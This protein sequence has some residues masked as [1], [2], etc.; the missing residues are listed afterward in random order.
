MLLGLKLEKFEDLLR[1][2]LKMQTTLGFMV[3][4]RMIDG[5]HFHDLLNLCVWGERSSESLHS[6]IVVN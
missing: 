3:A 1:K 6:T 4:L 5:A 2:S